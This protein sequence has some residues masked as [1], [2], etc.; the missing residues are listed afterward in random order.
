MK[1]YLFAIT[2]LSLLPLTTLLHP[3][4]FVAHD[5]EAHVVSVASFYQSLTEGNI[6]PRWS[7]SLNAGYGHPILMFLY[8]M[9]SYL[10]ALFHF[11]G[12]NFA[13]SIKLVLAIGY[14]GAGTFMYK[15]L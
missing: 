5:S 7:Q 8:P 3:G 10:S 11:L 1:K 15:W 6:F 13:D 9:S 2:I 12:W 14:I 4:M